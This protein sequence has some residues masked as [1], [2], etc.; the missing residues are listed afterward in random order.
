MFKYFPI[1]VLDYFKMLFNE[2]CNFFL[3]MFKMFKMWDKVKKN[4]KSIGLCYSQAKKRK[5]KLLLN[6]IN[7]RNTLFK[8]LRPS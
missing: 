2:S 3:E 5:K 1:I 7:I 4:I 6:A 8:L